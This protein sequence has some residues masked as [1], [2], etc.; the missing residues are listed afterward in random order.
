M[1]NSLIDRY[2]ASAKTWQFYRYRLAEEQETSTEQLGTARALTILKENILQDWKALLFQKK[3]AFEQAYFQ[4]AFSHYF[5]Q[6]KQK[7]DK[8]NFLGDILE[9][10]YRHL[11]EAWNRNLPEW[12]QVPWAQIEQY[13]QNLRKD[14]TLKSLADFLGRWQ[15]VEL[16]IVEDKREKLLPKNS[17]KPN[18]YGK[19]EVIGIHHSDQLSSILP[20]EIALLSHEDTELIFSKRFVEKKLLSFQYRSHDMASDTSME[21][22]TI[23]EP[24]IAERGPIILV[25]DT[26]GSMYGQPEQIAKAISFVILSRALRQKRPCYLISF[27]DHIKTL[28]LTKMGKELDTLIE[29]LTLS[30]HGGTDI[31]PALERVTAHAQS[32]KFLKGR[33]IGDF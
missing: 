8:L 2:P 18:P 15:M 9:P 30:F 27:S 3:Q 25:I 7:V 17:W 13:V 10:Y 32:R 4:D 16:E 26:S 19:S 6:L 1:I 21:E 33:R 14:K 12:E 23:K 11:G 29:F 5:Q 31:Q 24:K 20:A 22:E 28:E